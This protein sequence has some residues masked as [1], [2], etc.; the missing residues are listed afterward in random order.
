MILTLFLALSA[1]TPPQHP[2]SPAPQVKAQKQLVQDLMQANAANSLQSS[3]QGTFGGSGGGSSYTYCQSTEGS[4][5]QASHIS[6]TGSLD[7][8]TEGANQFTLVAN[9][10]PAVPQS[11][12]MFTYGHVQTNVP[13]ANG[14]LCISPFNPGI[15]RMTPQSLGQGT[16][17]L[18]RNDHPEQFT[19][20]TAGSSWNFQ[21]WYRDPTAGGANFNLSD[22]LHVDFAP[23][24]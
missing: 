24:P 5:G 13:F 12:G 4:S 9:G 8:A 2:V 7:L 14:T 23:A 15:Y 20:I 21:F 6:H 1:S 16:V 17:V 11:F 3:T 22:A 18:S 10:V 19:L